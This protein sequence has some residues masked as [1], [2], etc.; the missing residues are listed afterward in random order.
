MDFRFKVCIFWVKLLFLSDFY[1][2]VCDRVVCIMFVDI[3]IYL[4]IVFVYL[5]FLLFVFVYDEGF[6]LW[7]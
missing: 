5:F 3:L 7:F 4:I 2:Y 1:Y 6:V